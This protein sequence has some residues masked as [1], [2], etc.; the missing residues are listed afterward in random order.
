MCERRRAAL[1][2]VPVGYL[3]NAA[4][5]TTGYWKLNVQPGGTVLA[6]P[7]FERIARTSVDAEGRRPQSCG[8]AIPGHGLG[9]RCDRAEVWSAFDCKPSVP[10]PD[11][12]PA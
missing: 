7:A 5:L 2:W 11:G 8:L 4:Q 6:S 10:H 12:L 1:D 3:A 9:T